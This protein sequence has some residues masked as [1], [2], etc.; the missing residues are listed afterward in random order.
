MLPDPNDSLPG[1]ALVQAMNSL[2]LFTGALALTT[3]TLGVIAMSVIGAKSFAASY[4]IVLYRLGLTACVD[5]APSRI[6]YPSG[7]DLAT[8]SAP[9][10]PPAPGL[11]STTTD[12]P[13]ASV[14]RC[15]IRRPVIS[16]EPPGGN[17]TTSF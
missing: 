8:K 2:P 5:S 4:G 3:S 13:H 10:F 16:S 6:V 11:F 12:W 15:A 7:A 9:M 14:S 17:G 1:L